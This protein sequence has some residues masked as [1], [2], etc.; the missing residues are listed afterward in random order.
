LH[1]GLDGLSKALP[2]AISIAPDDVFFEHFDP[3]ASLDDAA[4]SGS[5]TPGDVEETS[6]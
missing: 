6:E 5:T 3:Q 1:R 2:C 4:L